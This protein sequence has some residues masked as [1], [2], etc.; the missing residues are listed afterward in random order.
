MFFGYETK[1]YVLSKKELVAEYSIEAKPEVL[2]LGGIGAYSKKRK[3]IVLS[4]GIEIKYRE[5]VK[6][7][8]GEKSSCSLENK[9]YLYFDPKFAIAIYGE[10]AKEGLYILT[11]KIEE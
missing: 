4:N 11:D 1:D 10:K 9:D 5:F 2:Y 7:Q 6:A 8:I 3:P